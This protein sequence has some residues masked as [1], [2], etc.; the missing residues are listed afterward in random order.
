MSCQYWQVPQ[1][2]RD[3]DWQVTMAMNSNDCASAPT[4]IEHPSQ[5]HLQRLTRV[6]ITETDFRSLLTATVTVPGSVFTVGLLKRLGPGKAQ[7]FA[8]ACENW[9]CGVGLTGVLGAFGGLGRRPRKSGTLGRPLTVSRWKNGLEA[10]EDP[11]LGGGV[12]GTLWPR[13]AISTAIA[14][15]STLCGGNNA[16]V[17]RDVFKCLL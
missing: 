8:A 15:L 17:S 10:V 6:S 4:L 5:Q 2:T 13:F 7:T 14:F 1:V 12:A 16:L 3:M 9:I 11:P